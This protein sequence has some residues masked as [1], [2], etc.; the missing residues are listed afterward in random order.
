MP[1]RPASPCTPP[2]PLANYRWI[3]INYSGG[4]D[5][6]AALHHV[7]AACDR[8]GVPRERLVVSHQCLGAME[9]PGTVDLVREH[10][11]HYGLRVEITRYRDRSGHELNL[12]EYVRKRRRWPSSQQRYC[13]SE[14]KRGPGGR[15]IVKLHREAPGRVLNIYGFRSEES[16]ARAAKTPFALNKRFSS[17]TR[18]VWDWLPIHDWLESDVWRIIGESP[19]RHHPAYTLGMPRLS[20]CFC[21]FA[22]RGALII[23]GRANPALLDEYCAVEAE[24]QHTFQNGRGIAEIRAAIRSG[25]QP[26]AP[27]AVWNM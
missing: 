20:C 9:W 3:I 14:F 21:I 1:E 7:I 23:A 4:K 5:S 10:A 24:I 16:P 19:L 2:G 25:E 26:A 12:L 15:V 22:P 6:Q 18:E 11:R 17:R 13:T 27:N 8:E